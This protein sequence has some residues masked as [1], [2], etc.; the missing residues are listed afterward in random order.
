MLFLILTACLLV[1]THAGCPMRPT[2]EQTSASRTAGDGGYRI[3]ISGQTNGY[4]P[5]AIHTISLQGAPKKLFKKKLVKQKENGERKRNK[6]LK[7]TLYRP[8]EV[9]LTGDRCNFRIANA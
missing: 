2:V 8:C 3:F 7:K 5:N 6:F 9:S 4:I 1:V